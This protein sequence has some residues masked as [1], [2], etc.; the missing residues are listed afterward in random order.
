MQNCG[1]CAPIPPLH[2]PHTYQPITLIS[3]NLLSFSSMLS[4]FPILLI[5]PYLPLFWPQSN[6]VEPVPKV[7]DMWHNWKLRADFKMIMIIQ[8]GSSFL[9]S[10][11]ITSC[12]FRLALLG[13]PKRDSFVTLVD[14]LDHTKNQP[15][16][17]GGVLGPTAQLQWCGLTLFTWLLQRTSCVSI[18]V[19]RWATTGLSWRS[20]YVL[21]PGVFV[22]FKAGSS[23]PRK[24]SWCYRLLSERDSPWVK[25]IGNLKC[26]F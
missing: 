25:V 10:N 18:K 14:S 9:V 7:T 6:T 12:S 22:S 13:T 4:N 19:S 8:S 2:M 23:L 21:V 26:F 11:Y 20:R 24:P 15:Q 3:A 5:L 17:S 16:S 1:L